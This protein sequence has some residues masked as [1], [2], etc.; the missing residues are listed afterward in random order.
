MNNLLRITGADGQAQRAPSV[1]VVDDDPGAIQIVYRAIQELGDIRFATN[2][3]EAYRLVRE[4]APDVILLD[5]EMP[6]ET[7]FELCRRI[8]SYPEF[9]EIA[10]IFITSHSGLDF[11]VQALEAGAADFIAKPISALSVQ[12]RL[13]LHL[14]LKQQL[15]ELRVLAG[16]DALTQL[17]NRRTIDET[18]NREW[19]R[20]R[21]S[22]SEISFVLLDVDHFKLYNDEYGHPAG[23]SCL[24]EVAETLR[25]I[26]QRP[27]D[28]AGRFGGEEFAL[29]LPD[30]GESGAIHVA[31]ALREAIVA[32]GVPH[33]A[34]PVA[35]VVTVSVGV[36]TWEPPPPPSR[37]TASEAQVHDLVRAADQALYLAK[38][39]GRN[40]VE[41][42]SV[43]EY[44]GKMVS[45]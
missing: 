6:G 32:R 41:S 12:L 16:T 17:A 30:T 40:I 1:L 8:K 19:T 43:R 4:R 9:S 25:G 7:G 2:G 33:E 22:G 15:D 39:R 45:L 35:S 13:S 11:E 20:S 27:A 34:S 21:R 44:L 36:S 3:A 29:I 18:L 10:V 23:D 28:I 38:E 42:Q 14:K 26:A 37:P 31:N 5:A 24:Q